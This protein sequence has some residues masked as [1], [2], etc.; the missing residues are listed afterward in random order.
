ME[1]NSKS[2]EKRKTFPQISVN[3]ISPFSTIGCFATQNLFAMSGKYPHTSPH[4]PLRY[5]RYLERPWSSPGCRNQCIAQSSNQPVFFTRLQKHLPV[6][7]ER[8]GKGRGST[9]GGGGGRKIEDR[10]KDTKSRILRLAKCVGVFASG[11]AGPA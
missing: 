4:Q 10:E 11:C 5:G 8:V 3:L 9:G 6:W 1:T 7:E 2:S